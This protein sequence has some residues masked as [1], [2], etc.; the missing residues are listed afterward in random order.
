MPGSGRNP[1]RLRLLANTPRFSTRLFSMPP[2]FTSSHTLYIGKKLQ[3]IGA[4]SV[5]ANLETL[6]TDSFRTGRLR[7][8]AYSHHWRADSARI[9]MTRSAKTPVTAASSRSLRIKRD[10][11]EACAVG[12]APEANCA[13]RNRAWDRNPTRGL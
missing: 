11:A 6:T 3:D 9:T 10:V 13:A 5:G 2:C 4:A 8:V 1:F 7:R 12:M